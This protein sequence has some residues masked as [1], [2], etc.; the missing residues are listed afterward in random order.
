MFFGLVLFLLQTQRLLST[1]NQ[2]ALRRAAFLCLQS[3]QIFVIFVSVYASP[4]I[5]SS[6]DTAQTKDTEQ[7]SARGTQHQ[8][9]PHKK[10]NPLTH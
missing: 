3:I 10:P 4:S 7:K 2:L 9:V 6:T 1:L 8:P 5:P